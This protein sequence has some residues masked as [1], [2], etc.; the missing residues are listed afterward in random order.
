MC[1]IEAV[2]FFGRPI[3]EVLRD[4]CPSCP[5]CAGFLRVHTWICQEQERLIQGGMRGD[6]ALQDAI[7]QLSDEDHAA[8]MCQPVEEFR[9]ARAWRKEMA[10]KL[11]ARRAAGG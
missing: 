8:W 1:D 9:E 4:P 2:D 3:P 6:D 5:V 10:A 11:K 7:R